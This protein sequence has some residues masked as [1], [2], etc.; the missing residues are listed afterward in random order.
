MRD[1]CESPTPRDHAAFVARVL[2]RREE[3]RGGSINRVNREARN[4]AVDRSRT[5]VDRPTAE[6]SI[7]VVRPERGRLA[8][9][10]Y[11][12]IK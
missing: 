10:V 1:P 8:A 4:L 12:V 5:V 2:R 9:A 6:D 3:G 11:D 7:S